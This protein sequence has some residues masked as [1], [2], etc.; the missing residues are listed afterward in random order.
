[1]MACRVLLVMALALTAC[2]SV[3]PN[4]FTKLEPPGAGPHVELHYLGNGGWLIQREGHK[5]ATAPFVSNPNGLTL[6][7]PGGPDEKLIDDDQVIPPMHDVGIILIGHGHYDHAMDL[8]YVHEK[9]A[10]NADIY[11]SRTVANT[12]WA[13]PRLR[14][15]LKEIQDAGA[16]SGDQPGTWLPSRTSKVR[17]MPLRSTHAPH[18]AGLKLIPWWPVKDKQTKL[19]CCPYWWKEG[20]T[21]AFIIDFLDA[22]DKV[23]FRIYYQDAATR[24]GTG[25]APVFEERDTARVDVAIL[26]VAAFDQFDGNPEHILT[27]LQPRNVVGGHW[28]DFVFQSYRDRPLRPAPGTSLED[29]H[30]RAKELSPKRPIYL[31]EP[32]Q[33]VYIPIVPRP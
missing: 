33:K 6:L 17:F 1:M 8:P 24:P 11:G 19:P 18:F 2:S 4:T 15:R 28:E 26:C 22:D 32:G 31:P 5:I 13:V 10:P 23:E 9:K 7:F 30:R 16:A 27:N 20:E 21:Y 3:P 14:P 29:F 12:L 25:I